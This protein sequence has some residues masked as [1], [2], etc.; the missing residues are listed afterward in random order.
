MC[1]NKS[2]VRWIL[3]D[4]QLIFFFS[5]FV[6]YAQGM[7]DYTGWVETNV[8]ASSLGIIMKQSERIMLTFAHGCL[9]SFRL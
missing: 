6:S 7:Q 1:I 5:Q 2:C 8:N 3:V 9:V 4:I